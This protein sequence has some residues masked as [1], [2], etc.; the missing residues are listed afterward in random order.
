M[1]EVA[2]ECEPEK[3]ATSAKEPIPSVDDDALTPPYVEF[4]ECMGAL[5]AF[6]DSDLRQ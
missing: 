2:E 3:E 6:D 1:V 5:G 4:I